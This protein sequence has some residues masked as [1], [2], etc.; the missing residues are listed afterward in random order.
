MKELKILIPVLFFLILG[1]NNDN[2]GTVV[3]GERFIISDTSESHL[4]NYFES[5]KV[6]YINSS[7]SE[8][9]EFQINQKIESEFDYGLVIECP[10]NADEMSP[11]EGT[12]E[13]RQVQITNEALG[14]TITLQHRAALTLQSSPDAIEELFMVEGELNELNQIQSASY[15][16]L[17]VTPT[18]NEELFTNKT[19]A[20]TFASTEFLNVETINYLNPGFESDFLSPRLEIA[21]NKNEGI[22]Q[23]LD[24]QAS[25]ELVFERFE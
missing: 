7:T 13:F 15:G 8:Q 5:E 9:I 11:L 19:A 1:C 23:I 10:E 18:L 17:V 20:I 4:S 24:N 21:Y 3:V 14:I 25:I 12:S 16:L 2:C 22:V 6:I